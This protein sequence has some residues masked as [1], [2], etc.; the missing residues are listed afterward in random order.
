MIEMKK[1]E[2]SELLHDAAITQNFDRLLEIELEL[3]NEALRLS[4]LDEYGFNDSL[5]DIMEHY[6]NFSSKVRKSV[7]RGEII[8]KYVDI[9]AEY[10]CE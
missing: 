9:F 4:G 6:S 2:L 5:T 3:L 10:C 8:D 1:E 7:Y